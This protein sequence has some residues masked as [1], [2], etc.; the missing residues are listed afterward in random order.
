MAKIRYV[1][2]PDELR[3]AAEQNPE[4]LPSSMRQIRAVYRTD[5]DTVAAVVPR[6]LEPCG[7]GE[8]GLT[9]SDVTMHL[10]PGIDVTIGAAIF[11]VRVIYEG[12][13]GLYLLTMPM[14]T[15]G[16]VV[17]GRET[18]GEPKKIADIGFQRDGDSVVATVARHGITYMEIR[19]TVGA[20]SGA[21]DWS[22]YA[23]CY[24]AMPS[25][26]PDRLFDN[27]PLLVRL[28]WHHEMKAVHET[29]HAQIILRDSPFDPVADLPVRELVSVDYEE[30]STRS[31]G[32]VLRAVPGDWLAPYLHQRYDDTV[33]IM[34]QMLGPAGE[35]GAAAG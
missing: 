25:C 26:E 11:G 15:E 14:T 8:V 9:F 30:G 22:S 32:R 1:K 12:I 4:F 17:G 18:Y 2:T 7:N 3:K 31:T 16:A 35:A 13:E 21:R 20:S 24:K 19:A 23:Y 29:K 28:E 6:P 10:R 27:D 34:E 5:P 33:S